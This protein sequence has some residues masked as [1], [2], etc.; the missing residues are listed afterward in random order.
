[1]SALPGLLL[2]RAAPSGVR[3]WLRRGTVPAHLVGYA[4]WTVV[5][6]A[7]D[8]PTSAPYDDGLHVSMSRPV[9]RSLRPSLGLFVLDA[10]VYL[11][12]RSQERS[13]PA[14]WA[15]WD[16]RS[17]TQVLPDHAHLSA[18]HL[19]GLAGLESSRSAAVA[20]TLAH[21]DATPARWVRTLLDELALPGSELLDQGALDARV[22]L[23][24]ITPASRHADRFER[25]LA[26]EIEVRG[27]TTPTPGSP[28][29]VTTSE[30]GR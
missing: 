1:M 23:V 4:D 8:P 12:A 26:E 27:P 10:R 2:L 30:D 11:V 13:A 15:V 18:E 29:S 20:T 7:G 22:D 6:P 28:E 17:G 25:Q 21:T 19:T 9:P 5:V 3:T 14:R 16:Q 24:T